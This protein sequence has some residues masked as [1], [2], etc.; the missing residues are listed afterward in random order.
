MTKFGTSDLFF[1]LTAICQ[2]FICSLYFNCINFVTTVPLHS[3]TTACQMVTCLFCPNCINL[4]T[5][6]LLHYCIAT[7]LIA[8]CQIFTHLLCLCQLYQSSYHRTA[9]LLTIVW[10][11]FMYSLRLNYINPITIALLHYCIT[12]R[13][14][15]MGLIRANYINFVTTARPYRYPVVPLHYYTNI[16]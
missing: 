8:I 9:T 3:Y 7:L 15:F 10:Q 14:I 2:V 6:I 4:I 12:V 13:W 11:V 5:T 16:Y 1:K